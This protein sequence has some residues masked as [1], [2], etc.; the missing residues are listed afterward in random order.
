MPDASSLPMHRHNCL[1][2]AN[3]QTND[4]KDVICEKNSVCNTEQCFCQRLNL[5]ESNVYL[6]F[7]I[8][9]IINNSVLFWCLCFFSCGVS[10]FDLCYCTCITKRV[11]MLPRSQLQAREG[12]IWARF[13]QART[14]LDFPGFTWKD[15]HGWH[16]KTFAVLVVHL[17]VSW[18]V[19]PLSKRDHLLFCVDSMILGSIFYKGIRKTSLPLCVC[20]STWGS[21]GHTDDS[22]CVL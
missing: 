19:K 5:R 8:M 6:W 22:D 3:L 9:W 15:Y 7:T 10:I 18:F 20:T 21:I 14:G 12:C 11:I 4:Y 2:S 13:G 1:L 17:Q 16:I